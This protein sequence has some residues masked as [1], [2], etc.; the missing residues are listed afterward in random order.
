MGDIVCL[1]QVQVNKYK[2]EPQLVNTNQKKFS[3]VF[4]WGRSR[5]ETTSYKLPKNSKELRNLKRKHPSKEQP[6]SRNN[7]EKELQ[8]MPTCSSHSSKMSLQLKKLPTSFD[9]GSKSVPSVEEMV[10]LWC[11]EHSNLTSIPRDF[12]VN[13]YKPCEGCVGDV[14]Q[15]GIPLL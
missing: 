14:T 10:V 9:A 5:S 1:H 11:I 12:E 3:V 15:C 2:G 6:K 13:S 8:Y 4:C 7:K